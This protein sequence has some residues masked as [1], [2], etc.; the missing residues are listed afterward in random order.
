MDKE[1]VQNRGETANSLLSRFL[2]ANDPSIAEAALAELLADHVNPVI[3]QVVNRKL[4]F[5]FPFGK[6]HEAQQEEDI[7]ST[8]LL[9]LILHLHQLRS[10]GLHPHIE[11]FAAYISA[12]ASNTCNEMLRSKYPLRWRLKNRIRYLLKHRP[13][14]DLCQVQ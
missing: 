6:F 14:F 1:Q 3:R 7:R 11:D 2:M 13:K 8:I 5:S 12:S 10:S 9:K 4:Y